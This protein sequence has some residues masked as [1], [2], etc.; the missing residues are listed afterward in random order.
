MAINDIIKL[1][2]FKARGSQK[3]E[4]FP[5]ELQ[6]KPYLTAHVTVMFYSFARQ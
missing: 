2:L 3:F 5:L 1:F 4:C 6:F